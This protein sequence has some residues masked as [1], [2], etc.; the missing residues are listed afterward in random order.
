MH[1]ESVL[2]SIPVNI[3][4]AKGGEGE[5]SEVRELGDGHWMMQ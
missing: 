3:R 2:R 5:C 1:F 4:K